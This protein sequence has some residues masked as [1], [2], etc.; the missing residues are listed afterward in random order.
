MKFDTSKFVKTLDGSLVFNVAELERA[1]LDPDNNVT[2]K[3]RFKSNSL[4]P[5]VFTFDTKAERDVFWN[6][7]FAQ[8][9]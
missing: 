5:H 8:L 3:L 9:G 1:Y 7:L 2:I 6:D 4:K